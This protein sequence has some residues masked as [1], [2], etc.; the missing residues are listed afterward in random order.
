MYFLVSLER[1]W[2][3]LFW[4]RQHILIELEYFSTTLGWYLFILCTAEGLKSGLAEHTIPCIRSSPDLPVTFW[5]NPV[6][7]CAIWL[8]QSYVLKITVDAYIMNTDISKYFSLRQFASHYFMFRWMQIK[9]LHLNNNY[10]VP[11]NI[12]SNF[13]GQ[14]LYRIWFS[15][16]YP[17]LYVFPCLNKFNWSS[18]KPNGD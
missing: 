5:I 4:S 14:C 3:R 17:V 11:V 13:P 9:N 16:E 7:N 10:T 6:L 8:R 15:I 2:S 1:A 18:T 12:C